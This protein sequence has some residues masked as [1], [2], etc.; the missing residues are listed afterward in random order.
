MYNI[1][2]CIYIHIHTYTYTYFHIHIYT[3]IHIH[4]YT[5]TT[6][7]KI[8]HGTPNRSYIN[9]LSIIHSFCNKSHRPQAGTSGLFVGAM[10][11]CNV[12]LCV[13]AWCSVL[14]C[15]IECGNP[16]RAWKILLLTRV[17]TRS[18]LFFP[19]LFFSCFR[20]ILQHAATQ[21][22]TLPYA[23]THCNTLQHTTTHCHTLQ[24]AAMHCH[25]LQHTA[26]HCHT[27]QHTVSLYL[28]ALLL[29]LS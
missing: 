21:C 16:K 11:R 27:L 17:H 8:R 9:T 14:H 15:T 12:L 25:T 28:L 10:E 13:A 26:T 6:P 1:Y 5:Y 20:S 23:A 22:N 19:H 3:Y 18:L 7:R 2:L 4:I 24:H 29:F